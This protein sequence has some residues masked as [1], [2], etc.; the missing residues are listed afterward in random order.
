MALQEAL[1]SAADLIPKIGTGAKEFFSKLFGRFSN[2]IEA[3]KGTPK[4]NKLKAFLA[5]LF[6]KKQEFEGQEKKVEEATAQDATKT[7]FGMPDDILAKGVRSTVVGAEV[8]AGS[9]EGKVVDDYCKAVIVAAREVGDA[10]APII[11][12]AIERAETAQDRRMALGFGLKAMTIMMGSPNYD[13]PNKLARALDQFDTA[14]KAG[15]KDQRLVDFKPEDVASLVPQD[16]KAELQ[17][18]LQVGTLDDASAM[19]LQGSLAQVLTNTTPASRA[20]ALQLMG[21]LTGGSLSGTDRNQAL[22]SFL[23]LVNRGDLKTLSDKL[24]A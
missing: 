20:K 22:V 6:H 7:L 24:L 11:T 9:P 14:R 23:F 18:R 15:G 12:K 5:G 3:A 1:K 19:K 8:P 2:A 4:G 21:K 16:K 17:R 10:R 13:D